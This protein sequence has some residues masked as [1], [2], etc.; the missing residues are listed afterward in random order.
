MKPNALKVD[1]RDNV[2]TVLADLQSGESVVLAPDDTGGEARCA[3]TTVQPIPYGHKVAL[4]DISRD[5][6]VTK[7][8]APIGVATLPIAAGSHV[9]SHNVASRRIGAHP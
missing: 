6:V 1:P 7:Y 8:G 9:H 4:C 2:A 3:L 5:A